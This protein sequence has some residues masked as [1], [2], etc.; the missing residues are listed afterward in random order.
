MSAEKNQPHLVA[1]PI[2][3]QAAAWF[4]RLRADD[5]SR[6]DRERWKAWLESDPRHRDAYTRLER[7]WS[8]FGEH[9]PQPEIAQRVRAVASSPA[10]AARRPGRLWKRS[11]AAVASIAMGVL[12]AWWLLPTAEDLHYRTAIGEQA[13]FVLPDG[14]RLNL[15]T[16]TRVRVRYDN[17]RREL[18]LENG[19]AFFR[20]APEARPFTVHTD[21]G[22]V[23]AL[24]TE[25]EVYRL[26]DAIEVT[27]TEGRVQLLGA[28]D[29]GTPLAT[30]APGQR[31]RYGRQLSQ[32]TIETVPVGAIPAW[33]SGRLVFDDQPLAEAVAEFNRY[34]RHRIVLQGETLAAMHISGVFRSD[35]PRAFVEALRDGYALGLATGPQGELILSEV[36]R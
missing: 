26:A 23:R 22:S 4:A 16:D 18:L 17:H 27:L 30:L 6:S 3:R 36:R 7:L 13:A 21:D 8:G 9:A 31:A 25:F 2:R 19:R 11:L 28:N 35:D 32:P 24:G 20:V 1:E 33:V 10:P 5:V 34:T 29:G 14:S 12:V 15:D